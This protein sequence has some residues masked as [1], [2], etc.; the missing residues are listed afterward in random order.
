MIFH[1][2]RKNKSTLRGDEVWAPTCASLHLEKVTVSEESVGPNPVRLAK[3]SPICLKDSTTK[4]PNAGILWDGSEDA[5]R[6]LREHPQSIPRA[7]PESPD[8][9]FSQPTVCSADWT[10]QPSINRTT[11]RTAV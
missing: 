7:S 1:S 9:P 2:S 5:L 3:T 4:C 6:M 8:R 11:G 10:D